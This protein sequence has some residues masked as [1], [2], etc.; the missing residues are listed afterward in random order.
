[1]KIRDEKPLN[2]ITNTLLK[3]CGRLKHV[4]HQD[5]Y[6][7]ETVSSLLQSCMDVLQDN[8]DEDTTSQQLLSILKNTHVSAVIMVHDTLAKQVNQSKRCINKMKWPQTTDKAEEGGNNHETLRIIGLE[9]KKDDHVLGFTVTTTANKEIAVT[10]IIHGSVIHKQGLLEVG[11]VICEVNQRPLDGSM[12]LL[13]ELLR[14]NGSIQL[15]IRP[16]EKRT[17]LCKGSTYMKTYFSYNPTED[18]LL[19][20]LGLKFDRGQILNV[21]DQSDRCWWQA[22]VVD[23]DGVGTGKPGLIPSK[24]LQ[25]HRYYKSRSKKITSKSRIMYKLSEYNKFDMFDI[26]LYEEVTWLPA[27]SR[28]VVVLVS[29]MA[30]SIAYNVAQELVKNKPDVYQLPSVHC[31]SQAM[32]NDGKYTYMDRNVISIG[33]K[34]NKYLEYTENKD[35]VLFGTKYDAITDVVKSNKTC[36]KNVQA[37]NLKFLLTSEFMPYVIFITNNEESDDNNNDVSY[38]HLADH[39]MQYTTVKDVTNDVLHHL[40][41]I[42]SQ[43]QWIP[44]SWLY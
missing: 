17:S 43:K 15:K 23:N 5:K 6:Q 20:C 16:S 35:G 8:D 2:S 27:F 39:V 10:R 11:D 1:M 36:V 34:N 32:C 19:P 4:Y 33:L 41:Q 31:S 12:E 3:A 37:S 18:D 42:S 14:T 44:L 29:P 7:S 38:I 28:Q 22:Q 13:Q 21:L 26:P 30:G 9:R 40:Q 24:Q 25:E